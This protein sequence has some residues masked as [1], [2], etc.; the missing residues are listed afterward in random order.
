MVGNPPW[1]IVEP[2]IDEFFSQFY[3]NKDNPKFSLLTK[4]E[5]NKIIEKMLTDLEIKNKWM[6]YHEN[7]YVLQSFFKNSEYYKFQKPKTEGKKNKIKMN[8]YKLFVEI[9]FKILKK[10][11][12]TGMITPSGLYSDLGSSGLRNY[13]FEKN[14]IISLYGFINKKGMFRDIHRQFKFMILICKKGGKTYHFNSGFHLDGINKSKM[15]KNSIDYDINLTKSISPNA[16]SIIEITSITEIEIFKKIIQFPMLSQHPWNLHMQREFN[17]TDDSPLF[18]TIKK[19]IPVYE[20]KMINQFNH[21]FNLPRYW[22]D[23]KKASEILRA[24]ERQ[25]IS[26]VLRTSNIEKTLNIQ[27][28]SDC[29]RLVWRLTTNATNMRTIICTVLPP[30]IVTVNSLNYIRPLLFDGKKFIK[31]ISTKELFYLCGMLNSFVVDFV[32]RRRVAS[33]INIFHMYEI[34]I[35]RLFSDDPLMKKLYEYTAQLICTTNEF[36]QIKN[37]L[38]IKNIDERDKTISKI[39]ALSA[40]IYNLT[41]DELEYVLKDFPIVDENLKYKTLN[42]F[43]LLDA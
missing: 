39:N 34:R 42:E 37:E 10:D 41:K 28:P 5:K 6:K 43:D 8:L 29:Y 36:D 20:G 22:I 21:L 16:L 7:T 38:K 14:K 27:I 30:N 25:K 9:F 26:S 1:D 31:T 33:A 11:G 32:M 15:D 19:G 35:P 24:R 3:N 40:K 17:I 4:P 23:S 18:N 2:N 12:M 13:F